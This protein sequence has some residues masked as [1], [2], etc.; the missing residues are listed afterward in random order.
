[1]TKSKAV[2]DSA[3]QHGDK[4]IMRIGKDAAVWRSKKTGQ[5]HREGGP[6]IEWRDGRKYWYRYNECHRLDGPAIENEQGVNMYYVDGRRFTEDEFYRYV[7]QTTGEVLVPP[8]KKL[9]HDRR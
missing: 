5:L 7:D 4:S 2:I 3:V 6:A 1:M 8:G 9:K